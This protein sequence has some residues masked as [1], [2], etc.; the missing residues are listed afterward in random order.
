MS[1]LDEFV[2]SVNYLPGEV[3][4]SL[5]LIKLLDDEAKSSTDDLSSL[6][7]KYFS[8][9]EK[10]Q[11]KIIENTEILQNIRVKQQKAL[12]FSDEKIAV[13]KQLLDMIEYHTN[14]LK[15]D[16]DAYKKEAANENENAEEKNKKKQ[17]IEKIALEMEMPMSMYMENPE[18]QDGFDIQND[19]NKTYCYC[20]KVSYGEMIECEGSTVTYI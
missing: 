18:M 13:A 9:L 4:R 17:K 8:S 7:T 16:I 1:Y 10:D 11:G 5:E 6:S 15:Q 20:G 2:N 14:K 19:E 3:C 12:N